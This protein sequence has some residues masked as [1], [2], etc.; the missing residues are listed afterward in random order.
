MKLVIIMDHGLRILANGMRAVENAL[1][2]RGCAVRL[3][4]AHVADEAYAKANQLREHADF[5]DGKHRNEKVEQAIAEVN[6]EI[7]H[8]V[9]GVHRDADMQGELGNKL[10]N[11]LSGCK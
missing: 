5:V 4:L 2:Y 1:Y 10:N 11:I 7:D 3:R 9:A 8:R 6:K